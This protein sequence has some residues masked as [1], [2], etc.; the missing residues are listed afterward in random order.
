MVRA[1]GATCWSSWSMS[2]LCWQRCQKPKEESSPPFWEQPA[3]DRAHTTWLHCRRLFLLFV[4]RH[5][6]VSPGPV[7]GPSLV[8]FGPHHPPSGFC[9]VL[10]PCGRA[11]VHREHLFHFIYAAALLAPNTACPFGPGD[12]LSAPLVH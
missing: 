5:S 12:A 7:E 2:R 8:A 4:S 3:T 1:P 11:G 10:G 6:C 9:Q